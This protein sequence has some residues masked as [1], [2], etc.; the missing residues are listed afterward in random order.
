MRGTKTGSAFSEPWKHFHHPSTCAKVFY[1]S[2]FLRT[3]EK[4][5]FFLYGQR[6]IPGEK[7]GFFPGKYKKLLHRYLF[8]R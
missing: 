6:V 2:F 7:P 1:I 5:G 3:A 8:S 4:P